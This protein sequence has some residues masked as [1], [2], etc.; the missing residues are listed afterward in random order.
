MRS[1]PC[2]VLEDFVQD[3][4]LGAKGSRTVHAFAALVP[5]QPLQSWEDEPEPLGTGS[6]VPVAPQPIKGDQIYAEQKGYG[7]VSSNSAP[8]TIQLLPKVGIPV[9]LQPVLEFG[10]EG[11]PLPELPIESCLKSVTVGN[12]IAGAHVD[13]YVNGAWRG[14]A[15]ATAATVEVPIQFGP[16][17][18]GDEV[19][20]RQWICN[21]I[22][23]PGKPVRIISSAGSYYTTQTFDV[24]HPGWNPFETLPLSIFRA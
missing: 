15:I 19:A 4:V 2:T 17:N 11:R 5:G 3:F 21:S 20:A 13:V 24:G 14:R 22:G 12:L 7:L 9:I 8:V 18:I 23:G 10:V 16:L 1:E 6:D